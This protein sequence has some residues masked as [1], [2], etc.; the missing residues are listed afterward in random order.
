MGYFKRCLAVALLLF[1]AVY[2]VQFQAGAISGGDATFIL[3]SD[4]SAGLAQ[5]LIIDSNNCPSEGPTTMYVTGTVTNTSGAP[6]VDVNVQMTAISAGYG[7]VGGSADT[8]ALGTMATGA[9]QLVGW[10]ITFPCTGLATGSADIVITDENAGSLTSTLGYTVRDALSAN[11]GGEVLTTTLGPGAIVGQ[12]VYMDSTYEFGGAAAGDEYF[13]QP[14]GS[15]AF[16]AGCFK[17]VGTDVVSSGV[18]AITAGTTDTLH[19]IAAASQPG[20]GHSATIRY[21]FQYL[22]AGVSTVAR[23]YSAQTSGASNLK[24]S[25]NFDGTGSVDITY[26]G[27]TNPFTITKSATPDSFVNSTGGT[28]TFTVNIDNPSIHDSF[29]DEI[30]DILPAGVIFT[31][32]TAASDITAANSNAIP[33]VGAT[34]TLSF[35]GSSGVSYAIPGMSSI[36]LVYTATI[37]DT[38]GS[39]INTAEGMIGVVTTGPA[40]ETVTVVS[41]GTLSASKSVATFDPMLLGMYA[42]PGNDVIYTIE[43]TNI[44]PSATSADTVEIIDAVPAEI[45]YYNGDIDDG[46][47]E[48]DPVIGIDNGSGMTL[49]YATDVAYSS[50]GTKPANFAACTDSPAAGYDSTITYICIN[51]KGAMAAGDPDPSYQLQFRARIK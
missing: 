34:G 27:A 32:L 20:N 30:T 4:D 44:G 12:V 43:F 9:T 37:P 23:P 38:V 13:L 22:C 15:S 47:P 10:L 17:L 11:A 18:D 8:I 3:T 25:V 40:S 26:P 31:G 14:A 1:S 41:G 45:E 24:Y 7:L 28:A 2:F 46:G 36:D 21:Y 49:T 29:I 51:P 39:Y 16:D 33:L 19:F 48:T 50:A 5:D 42:V 35:S 6:L